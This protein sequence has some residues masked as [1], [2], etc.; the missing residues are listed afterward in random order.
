MGASA[1][2]A[3]AFALVAVD[4]AGAAFFGA[5][6]DL[7]LGFFTAPVFFAAVVLLVVA[8]EAGLAFAGVLADLESGLFC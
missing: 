1:F 3:G 4:L 6:A 7:A 5:A 8:F 2:F